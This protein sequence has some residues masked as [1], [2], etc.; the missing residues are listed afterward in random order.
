ME[1]AYA[2]MDGE[3]G[4]AHGSTVALKNAIGRIKALRLE[5]TEK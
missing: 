3:V 1:Q 2:E 4:S 5:L